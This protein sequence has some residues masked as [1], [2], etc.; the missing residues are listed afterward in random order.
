MQ[1]LDGTQMRGGNTPMQVSVWQSKGESANGITQR[2]ACIPIIDNPAGMTGHRMAGSRFFVEIVGRQLGAICISARY[3][4]GK[5]HYKRTQHALPHH[6]D[7]FGSIIS[8]L[9]RLTG[10]CS[11]VRLTQWI[12]GYGGQRPGCWRHMARCWCYAT[13]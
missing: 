10:A 7:S 5:H 1:A 11:S 13:A 9:G 12:G 3:I 8:D 6:P 4:I 2:K